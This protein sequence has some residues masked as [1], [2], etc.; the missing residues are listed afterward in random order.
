MLLFISFSLSSPKSQ[1]QQQQMIFI[2]KEIDNNST[3]LRKIKNKTKKYKIKSKVEKNWEFFYFCCCC[4]L[5]EKWREKKGQ[6]IRNEKKETGIKWNLKAKEIR[7][8]RRRRRKH[9][10]VLF[11][12]YF[13]FLTCIIARHGT[14]VNHK[15]INF[16]NA[17]RD[18]QNKVKIKKKKMLLWNVIN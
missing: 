14:E 17:K 2:N 3:A 13:F 12:I 6:R 15:E 16:F 4:C 18:N 5:W 1:Q 8:I 11:Y 7:I 9:R 10:L